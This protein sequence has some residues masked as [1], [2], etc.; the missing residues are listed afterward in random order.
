MRKLGYFY[1]NTRSGELFESFLV[2]AV[3]SLL[4]TR[5]WLHLTHY[6][7]IGNQGVHVA[8][9]LFGGIFMVIAFMLLFAF[10]GSRVQR[11]ASLVAGVGF[12]LFIDE[13]GKF[14]TSNNNYF[15]SPTIALIYLTFVILFLIFRWLKRPRTLSPQENL[16]NALRIS[17]GAVMYGLDVE[18]RT[19]AL[20]YLA[21][22]DSNHPLVNILT[23]TLRK[24]PVA[25]PTRPSLWQ[26]WRQGSQQIYEQVVN[27]AVGRYLLD[28]IF[29]GQAAWIL[30]VVVVSAL[31]TGGQPPSSPIPYADLLDFLSSIVAAGFMIAGVVSFRKT[32][33]WR[34]HLFAISLLIDIFIV[35]FFEF[36][37]DQFVALPSFVVSVVL[38]MGVRFVIEHEQRRQL[39]V[40]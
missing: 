4:A 23:Q 29:A 11:L 2:A 15:Y 37:K 9:M 28:A 13:L 27:H 21:G 32:R 20:H 12:G 16:L 38:Y 8:H 7:T 6:P 18:D 31:Q 5:F 14:I 40:E 10:I 30:G 1:R 25:S 35:H 19:Q 39:A 22:A 26:R 3:V 34:Y 33:L 17:E 24:M 36:Y